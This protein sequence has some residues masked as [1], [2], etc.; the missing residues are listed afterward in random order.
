[1]K[2][3]LREIVE[4][5][6]RPEP[7]RLGDPGLFGPE[8]LVWRVNGEVLLLAG[9]GRALLLQIAHPLVAAGVADHSGFDRDPWERLWATLGA[10]LAV[11]FGD[12]AQARAAADRVTE[13]HKEVRGLREGTPYSA[14]DPELL[15]WVHATLV[16]SAIVTYE[17][18]IGAMGPAAKERYY[19]EMKRFASA[20]GVP[21]GVLP[22]GFRAFES[23][24]TGRVAGLRVTNEARKLV[25][26]VLDPPAPRV[27]SP[28][29]TVARTVTIGL[30]PPVVREGFGF[31]WD[32]RREGV[33]GALAVS[34]RW[35]R[36][37]LPDRLMRWPHAR[38]AEG[39]VSPSRWR[40]QR[41]C[42][43]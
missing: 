22:A 26:G 14:L 3:R 4:G 18:F 42:V 38:R 37:A 13:L 7:G 6:P 40:G 12:R 32:R 2:P 28:V 1:M 24:M 23:W 29:L 34:T 15:A 31:G 27:L 9:G 10:V 33:V 16:D 5:F 25:P 35:M 43:A 39:R 17:R 20:F 8:S 19:Q 11:A 41:R 36:A 21:E 30:L